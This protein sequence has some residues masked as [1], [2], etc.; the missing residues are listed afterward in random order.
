MRLC[1][2][3]L[4]S[5]VWLFRTPWTIACQAPLSV[6]FSWQEYWSGLPVPSP[7]DLSDPGI[8]PRSPTLQAD[9]LLPEPPGKPHVRLCN[10]AELCAPCGL[11]SA[12]YMLALRCQDP[13]TTDPSDSMAVWPVSHHPVFSGKPFCQKQIKNWPPLWGNWC[14]LLTGIWIR[15]ASGESSWNSLAIAKCTSLS[16]PVP[17]LRLYPWDKLYFIHVCEIM[18]Y[19]I[20]SIHWIF[21]AA[22]F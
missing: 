14:L 4:L 13:L 19:E 11:K 7:G 3:V 12:F 10:C 21:I 15:I 22:L 18:K 17:F 20:M 5:R 9:S 8:K 6:G 1:V 2:C 16:G